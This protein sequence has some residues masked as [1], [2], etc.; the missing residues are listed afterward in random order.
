M[1]E[2]KNENIYIYLQR[3]LLSNLLIGTHNIFRYNIPSYINFVY[4]ILLY[5]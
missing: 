4:A 1:I 3:T 5:L 2:K